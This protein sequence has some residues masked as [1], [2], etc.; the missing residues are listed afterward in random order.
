MTKNIRFIVAVWEIL[1]SQFSMIRGK[2][3]IVLVLIG[4][5]IARVH[6][7][8]ERE[9]RTKHYLASESNVTSCLVT[10]QSERLEPPLALSQP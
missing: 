6:N 2:S 5:V 7:K 9:Y 3:A 8:R 1:K 4:Y 10:D